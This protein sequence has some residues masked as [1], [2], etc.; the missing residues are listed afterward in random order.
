MKK[1]I[2]M[3]LTIVAVGAVAVVLYRII[4]VEGPD[5]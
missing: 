1:L 4:T 2:Y 3:A 5:R